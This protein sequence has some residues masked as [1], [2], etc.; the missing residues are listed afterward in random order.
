[1]T[2]VEL[3]FN[4]LLQRNLEFRI[5]G[6]LVKEGKLVLINQ[7]DFYI[8]L[9]LKLDNNETKKYEIPYPFKI[10]VSEGILTLEYTI[11][12]FGTADHN[13]K[14]RLLSL[15]K[16]TNSKLYNNR[17]VIYEKMA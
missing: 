11:S 6:K 1:M 10:H 9:Y 7:K 17:L 16:K 3:A 8:N 12:S 13:I 14:Y 5:D 15:N 2:N 4:N